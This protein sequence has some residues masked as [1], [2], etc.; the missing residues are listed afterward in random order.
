MV[1]VEL[2]I[3]RTHLRWC[4]QH[5]LELKRPPWV[6][7]T[8]VLYPKGYVSML[9]EFGRKKTKGPLFHSNSGQQQREQAQNTRDYL[10][11][12]LVQ[13]I[14]C[15]VSVWRFFWF[16]VLQLDQRKAKQSMPGSGELGWIYSSQSHWRSSSQ[17][18]CSAQTKSYQED[19]R[20]G[21]TGDSEVPHGARYWEHDAEPPTPSV[22]QQ[23]E[24]WEHTDP[25]CSFHTGT[26][27][28]YALWKL[29]RSRRLSQ[30]QQLMQH[31]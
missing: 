3:C 18:T 20:C 21:S 17:S 11:V 23:S 2:R 29:T 14:A 15:V 30:Q 16:A 26:T 12:P 10:Q 9:K 28:N 31:H 25:H 5:R 4:L 8:V 19:A 22:P 7:V 27:F 13:A 6:S 24:S 1:Y